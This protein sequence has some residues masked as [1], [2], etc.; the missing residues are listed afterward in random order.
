MQNV[1]ATRR[2]WRGLFASPALGDQFRKLARTCFGGCCR[3]WR[4]P[5]RI[6]CVRS[7]TKLWRITGV[8]AWRRG[9]WMW[10]A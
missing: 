1:E 3:V 6:I 10:A 7:G 5:R 4:R 8:L 2:E 9:R